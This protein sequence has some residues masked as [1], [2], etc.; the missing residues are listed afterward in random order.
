M[1]NYTW[2]IYSTLGIEATQAFL[3]LEFKKN[4]GDNI[5]SRHVS[6]ITNTMTY[7]GEPVPVNQSGKIKNKE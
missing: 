5:S 1:C 2:N 4:V 7:I 3:F 6:T